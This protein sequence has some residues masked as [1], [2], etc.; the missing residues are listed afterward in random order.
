[1]V[2]SKDNNN[3][4]DGH[5]AYKED[6]RDGHLLPEE[7]NLRKSVKYGA[8][9]L[10]ALLGLGTGVKQCNTNSE[11]AE[12]KQTE[13]SYETAVLDLESS[14]TRITGYEAERLSR[15]QRLPVLQIYRQRSMSNLQLL[16]S[17]KRL[18]LPLSMR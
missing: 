7:D 2:D 18:K 9:G 8:A 3:R 6:I 15:K 13:A 14:N 17:S 10:I 11:I 16:Q 5:A 4:R 1:M 12:L